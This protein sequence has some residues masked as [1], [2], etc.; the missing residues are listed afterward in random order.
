[1]LCEG[2][3]L[4]RRLG[5]GLPYRLYNAVQ[6][7]DAAVRFTATAAGHRLPRRLPRHGCVAEAGDPTSEWMSSPTRQRPSTAGALIA[8]RLVDDGI[9]RR[10]AADLAALVVSALEGI[11]VLARQ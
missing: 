3:R 11:L 7:L 1:M 9:P 10:T 6:M 2:S 8:G 4:R 5:R